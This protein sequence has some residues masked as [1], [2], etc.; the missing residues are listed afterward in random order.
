MIFE[1][2]QR[3]GHVVGTK[4]AANASLLPVR[5][6]HEMRHN[7][8]A[9]ACEQIAERYLSTRTVKDIILFHL[10]PGQ[11][12]PQSIDL[13]AM[14]SQLFLFRQQLLAGGEPFILRNDPGIVDIAVHV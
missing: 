4:G 2:N 9:A 13:V 12:A 11:G 7:Q 14:T 8:L 3:P 6:K 10:R 5:A 1:M